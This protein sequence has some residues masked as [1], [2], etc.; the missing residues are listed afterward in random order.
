VN[1]FAFQLFSDN[2]DFLY[3]S[4]LH[5][6]GES[7][8]V[9]VGQVGILDVENELPRQNHHCADDQPYQDTFKI[10][11]QLRNLRVKHLPDVAKRISAASKNKAL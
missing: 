7:R 5:V 4:C 11:A 10:G 2:R 8:K 9:L 6:L 1:R 3:P